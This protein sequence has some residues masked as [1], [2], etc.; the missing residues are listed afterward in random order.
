MDDLLDLD[1]IEMLKDM[2][3]DDDPG[4]FSELVDTFAESAAETLVKLDAA[5][6]AADANMVRE[7]AHNIKGSS[8][9]I[10]AAK[11][12][13][14]AKAIENQARTGSLDGLEERVAELRAL[15]P[16]SRAALDSYR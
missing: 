16:A 8:A 11:M 7:Y 6:K 4:F 5:V 10:G 9:N 2:D 3:D 12:S 1:T 14:I 15:F 13:S